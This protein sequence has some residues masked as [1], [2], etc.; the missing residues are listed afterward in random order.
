MGSSGS[1]RTSVGPSGIALLSFD[2]R[3]AAALAVLECEQNIWELESTLS[4]YKSTRVLGDHSMSWMA[5]DECAITRGPFYS[6]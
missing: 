1:P 2:I 5:F 6:T 4:V 3:L